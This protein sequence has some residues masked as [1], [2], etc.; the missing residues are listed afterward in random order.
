[1]GPQSHVWGL[2]T[3]HEAF[4]PH[5]EPH[6]QVSRSTDEGREDPDECAQGHCVLGWQSA[7]QEADGVEVQAGWTLPAVG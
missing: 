1:M 2:K 3:M 4:R 6:G 5:M 7:E